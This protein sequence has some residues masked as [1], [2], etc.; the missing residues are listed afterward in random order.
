MY[1]IEVMK[2]ETGWVARFSDPQVEALFGTDTLPTAF[3]G[4]ADAERVV[5]EVRRLNPDCHVFVAEVVA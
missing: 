2:R 5:A 4:K 3:T 1:V